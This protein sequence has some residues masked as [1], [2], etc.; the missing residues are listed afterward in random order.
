MKEIWAGLGTGGIT[1]PTDEKSSHKLLCRKLSVDN[2][3]SR[4]ASKNCRI[5][6]QH[7]G[8]Q[9]HHLT[10]EGMEKPKK[11]ATRMLIASGVKRKSILPRTTWLACINKRGKQLPNFGKAIIRL[12]RRV[13]Y[14]HFTTVVTDNLPY[15]PD[16]VIADLARIIMARILSVQYGLQK[17]IV[18]RRHTPLK[19]VLPPS[20]NN[21]KKLGGIGKIDIFTGKLTIKKKIRRILI[22]QGVW[23][24]IYAKKKKNSNN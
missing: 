15:D 23:R 22:N 18:S 6:K 20:I 11:F 5:C 8:S 9:S 19:K 2:N 21:P 24:D 13:N 1:N 7:I 17:F 10:C 4:V 14:R 12:F 3:D 16:R